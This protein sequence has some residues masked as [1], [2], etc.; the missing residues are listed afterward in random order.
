MT[1][2]K[3]VIDNRGKSV[4]LIPA[5][6]G[7]AWAAVGWFGLLLFLAGL[8]D[9]L[10]AFIPTAFGTPEWEFGTVASVFASL[11]L[12][13]IGLAGLLASGVAR[14][15]RRLVLTLG[16]VLTLLGLAILALLVIF[17]TDVP[18]ALRAVQ[19]DVLLGVKK[20]VAKTAL[21]GVLFGLTYLYAGFKSIGLARRK[22]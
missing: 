19:G 20:A 7:L 4:P 16:I 14:G 17:F 10:I 21:L 1:T 2:P 22:A 9:P 8:G 5:D 12:V 3:V 18:M 13:T 11:P 15:R 6:P